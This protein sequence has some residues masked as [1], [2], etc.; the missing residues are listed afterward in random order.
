MNPLGREDAFLKSPFSARIGGVT[1]KYYGY[2]FAA[3]NFFSSTFT[4]VEGSLW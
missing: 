3:H 2:A 4:R 1:T